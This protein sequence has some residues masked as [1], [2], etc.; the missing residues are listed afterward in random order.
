MGIC[1][2]RDLKETIDRARG[3]IPRSTYISKLLE[4]I[5][6]KEDERKIEDKQP[7][8]SGCQLQPNSASSH[9]QT[10]TMDLIEN[11]QE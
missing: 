2:P 3:D 1:L 5:H 10:S 11:E 8:K 6:K 7:S 4:Q 9:L